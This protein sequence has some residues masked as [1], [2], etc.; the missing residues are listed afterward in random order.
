MK[1]LVSFILMFMMLFPTAYAEEL[2]TEPVGD[3][4]AKE[5]AQ[6]IG[7][8]YGVS[9]GSEGYGSEV[10][11]SGLVLQVY[12]A[13][14]VELPRNSALQAKE[15]ELV[16]LNEMIA[17][18]IVCFMYEDGSIGHVGIYIG[19]NSMIH[20]P[21]PEKTVEISSYFE[22]WGS[23]KAVYGRRIAVES[24][25]VPAELP[26]EINTQVV[27][28]LSTVNS[29]RMNHLEGIDYMPK[30]D[31]TE[32]REVIL[33]IDNPVMTVNGEEK[34]IDE[35][36]A[37]V[38]LIIN[39]RTHLPLR[40]VAEEFGAEVNWIGGDNGEI[41]LKYGENEITL[42]IDTDYAIANSETK[43][44]DST[45]IIIGGRTYLPIRF[46]A[47][48]F[49]WEL[50]WDGNEKT[51]TLSVNQDNYFDDYYYVYGYGY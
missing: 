3:R 36:G 17:G 29:L 2:V 13:F 41:N 35:S 11:C 7:T 10:D 38:P 25:Y 1:K 19:G 33:Q 20:S 46:I 12:K 31:I 14:G 27:K 49:G 47:D 34:L 43:Y 18:D 50:D 40:K 23:I 15:G 26:E 8:P 30:V 16:Q 28:S 24:D 9:D 42:W 6:W 5:A 4:I 51:V 39:N 45:P 48:E 37:V 44:I 22:D 21:R 32:P